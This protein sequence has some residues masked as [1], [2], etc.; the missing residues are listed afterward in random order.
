[1]IHALLAGIG[2]FS[3][4]ALGPLADETVA[5]DE[6]ANRLADV[7]RALGRQ[8]GIDVWSN[9]AGPLQTV[10]REAIEAALVSAGFERQ[11][12]ADASH[13][14]RGALEHLARQL[15]SFRSKG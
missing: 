2:E 9:I 11:A 6:R 12:A 1:M 13:A 14:W 5:H 7:R 4:S 15:R 3:R 8:Q 10:R